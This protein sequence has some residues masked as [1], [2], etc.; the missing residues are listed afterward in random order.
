MRPLLSVALIV[1][2]AGPAFAYRPFDSTDAAVADRGAVEFECGPIGYIVAAGDRSLIVPA[3][4]LNIG[5]ANG[6]EIVAEGKNFMRVTA[7]DLRSARLQDSAIS[8]KKVLRE[9]SLQDR[10]GLS[11]AF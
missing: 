9:G 2:S 8:M 4:I 11:I 1:L 3:A 6:W 10:P 7:R 5:L